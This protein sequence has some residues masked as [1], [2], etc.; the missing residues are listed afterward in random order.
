MSSEF[1]IKL[2]KILEEGTDLKFSGTI[3]RVNWRS[4]YPNQPQLVKMP[5]RLDVNKT[6]KAKYVT[7]QKYVNYIAAISRPEAT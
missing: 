7:K 1:D 3:I 6:A 2:A 5:T 4:Y